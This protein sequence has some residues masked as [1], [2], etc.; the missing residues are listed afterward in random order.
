MSLFYNF[1]IGG[2]SGMGAT[3]II[4][5]IDMIKVRIQLRG[6]ALGKTSPIDVAKE[7]YHQGGI[8]GFYRGLD[9]ALLR[10]AVY[11]SLR[12]GIYFTFND[13]AKKRNNGETPGASTR[14]FN[15]LAAGAIGSAIANP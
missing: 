8:K 11:A 3:S 9:S 7:I 10:Q 12:I 2:L 13:F 15:S 4:Q 5:P 1:L 14:A 6:E